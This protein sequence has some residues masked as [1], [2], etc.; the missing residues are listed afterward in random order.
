MQKCDEIGEDTVAVTM[1]ELA[2]E[3][4]LFGSITSESA[5]QTILS[6]RQLDRAEKK[7]IHLII[8]SGGG[9]EPAGWAIYDALCLTR[10]K[11]IGHCFG[12]CMSIAALI[13]QGCDSRLL[14]PNTR[15]MIHNGMVAYNGPLDKV[16]IALVEENFLTQMYYEKLAEKSNL[17][18]DKVKNLCDSETYLSAEE[19]VKA[20]FAD[21]IL[22]QMK[23]A[24]RKVRK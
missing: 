8:S 17:S 7:N 22:G 23:K 3:V 11:V 4:L 15:F 16:R 13:L 12:E 18:I 2:R 24:K 9:S 1:D 20:G 21:G 5:S 10:C 6:I 19:A 14:S